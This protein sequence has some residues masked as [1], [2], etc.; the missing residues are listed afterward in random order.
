MI[1]VPEAFVKAQAITAGRQEDREEQEVFP[2]LH[3]MM[4][5]DKAEAVLIALLA[6][7]KGAAT[8][9]AVHAVNRAGAELNH[10]AG[11]NGDSDVQA[12]VM[13][14]MSKDVDRRRREAVAAIAG[15]V[16]AAAKA[17][18]IHKAGPA[19]TTAAVDLL[20]RTAGEIKVPAVRKAR[21][22]DGAAAA[23][24][25]GGSVSIRTIMFI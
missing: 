14:V 18:D 13:A 10:H 1:Q 16:D 8:R 4:T 23:A 19:A 24:G 15:P 2:H 21:A 20:E 11:K 17:G 22:A 3:H 12:A 9:Q 25:K 5:V 6:P 7:D